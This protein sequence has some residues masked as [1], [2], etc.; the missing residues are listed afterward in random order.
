MSGRRCRA[1]KKQFVEHFDYVRLEPDQDGNARSVGQL[2]SRTIRKIMA[3]GK[4]PDQAVTE[5]LNRSGYKGSWTLSDLGRPT[6][7]TPDGY[8]ELSERQRRRLVPRSELKR[9][10]RDNR[11]MRMGRPKDPS[12]QGK[13]W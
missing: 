7:T 13:D 6:A 11:Y 4:T 12:A 2:M 10:A 9:M 3:R 8:D 5:V 1:I